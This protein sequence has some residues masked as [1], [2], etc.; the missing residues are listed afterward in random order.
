MN[1]RSMGLWVWLG[2]AMLALIWANLGAQLLRFGPRPVTVMLSDGAIA[3]L[4]FRYTFFS[5][6]IV[7]AWVLMLRIHGAYDH[8]LVGHGPEEYKAV[9]TASV[10]LFALVAVVSYLMRLDLARGY[11]ALALPA[12]TIGLLVARRLW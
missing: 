10:R 11:V 9:A 8:R 1:Q 7:G 4:D 3:S 12:G 5:A 6:V 2:I